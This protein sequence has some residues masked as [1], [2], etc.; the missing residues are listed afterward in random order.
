M[1]FKYIYVFYLCCSVK[2]YMN[3]GIIRCILKNKTCCSKIA[4]CQICFFTN[5]NHCI[6][7][8]SCDNIAV[9]V[10]IRITLTDLHSWFVGNINDQLAKICTANLAGAFLSFVVTFVAASITFAVGVAFVG[11]FIA[12]NIANAVCV[13]FVGTFVVA[14]IAN[15]V[16]VA[17]VDAF[18]AASIT[19][20]VGVAF[21]GAFIVANIT[22]TV[23]VAFVFTGCRNHFTC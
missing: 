12:A 17:F 4:K 8:C 9:L 20:A 5:I 23:C 21:V 7:I 6:R 14:N 10:I 22:N 2:G 1:W 13:A 19:F 3:H 15:T 18:V 16:G 11:A